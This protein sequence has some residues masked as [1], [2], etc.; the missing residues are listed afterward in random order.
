MQVGRDHHR[1][2]FD[3]INGRNIFS[4]NQQP[5]IYNYRAPSIIN[6]TQFGLF[7]PKTTTSTSH[8][9]DLKF[10]SQLSSRTI[11]NDYQRS[12]FRHHSHQYRRWPVPPYLPSSASR[13]Y[14]TTNNGNTSEGVSAPD[15]ELKLAAPITRELGQNQDKPC[16]RDLL[17]LN[18]LSALRA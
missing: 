8:L 17:S 12:I 15:L 16:R 18:C 11:S 14:T 13:S 7:S 5:N 2:Y 6:A 4:N 1:N 3:V 10:T 9:H